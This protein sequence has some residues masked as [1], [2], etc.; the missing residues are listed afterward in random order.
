M[1]TEIIRL[2]DAAVE[3]PQ[4]PVD[5]YELNSLAIRCGYIVDPKVCNKSVLE[6]ISSMHVNYNSTFYK[7]WEDVFN[8][9]RT[10]LLIDQLLHYA[11]TY[12]C[13]FHPDMT[14]IPNDLSIE[15]PYTQYKIIRPISIQ[16]LKDKC[17]K[18]I[19]SGIALSSNTIEALV[20]FMVEYN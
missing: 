20:D 10:S 15:I 9:S 17:I 19:M 18:M 14:W 5:V 1:N 13:D 16:E 8:S 12:G 2:F 4:N 11:S 6:F 7:C 3:D